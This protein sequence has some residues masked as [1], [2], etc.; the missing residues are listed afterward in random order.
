MESAAAANADDNR[1]GGAGD[2]GTRR[3]VGEGAR[4]HTVVYGYVTIVGGLYPANIG[5]GRY[6]VV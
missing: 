1:S 4:T 3:R 5:T 2:G 6:F